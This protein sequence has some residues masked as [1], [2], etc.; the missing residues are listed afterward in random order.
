[1]AKLFEEN[2]LVVL[3]FYASWCPPCVQLKPVLIK[4][5]EAAKNFILGAVDVDKE[6]N[7]SLST[8]FGVK[9]IVI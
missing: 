1:M 4:E 7:L 9:V 6:T 3:D 2:E 8:K 5:T